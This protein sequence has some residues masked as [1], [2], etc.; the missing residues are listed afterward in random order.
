[1]REMILNHASLV[2][3]GRDEAVAWLA[4]TA[5]GMAALVEHRAAAPSLRM[6]R[7]AHEVR[8]SPDRS[9][10]DAYQDLRRR[11]ALEEYRFLMRLSTKSPL[12]RDVGAD[13]ADR[14][15]RCEEKTL[16]EEDGAPLLLCAVTDAI[17]VSLPSEPAWDRDQVT[18]DFLEL[19]P[20]GSL[21][22]E[23]EPV[24]NLARPSHGAAIVQ[25][26]RERLPPP[27]DAAAFW[28]QREQMFPHLTFGPDVEHQCGALN[29][30]MLSTVVNRLRDLDRAAGAWRDGA[31]PSW[32]CK[33]TPESDRVMSQP[34]LREARRFRSVRGTR[35]IFE[36]HARFGS[37][38]RIHL[39]FD[40][41]VREIEI[42]YVG[43]HLPL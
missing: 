43:G 23:E 35:V 12:L 6:C 19:L 10:F 38:G 21:V 27:R 7:P 29:A 36:W 14:F 37:G 39:R 34:R 33:V 4:D 24:D 28:R 1:M 8:C 25:R 32:T 22:E 40:A 18:V 15:L 11:G 42:G 20:D 3:C 5:S 26:H 16:P 17:A 30:G 9:L 2:P 31:A 41:R 13:S